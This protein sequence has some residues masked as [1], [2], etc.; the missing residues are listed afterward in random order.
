M[1]FYNYRDLQLSSNGDLTLD[2]TGDLAMSFNI[3]CVKE[4]I[5][6]RLRTENPDWYHHPSIG[7]DIDTFVGEPNTEETAI[8]VV[9]SIMSCLTYD[10]FLLPSMIVVTPIP[11]SPTQVIYH[12]LVRNEGDEISLTIKF[13]HD[14]GVEEVL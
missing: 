4:S 8:K 5:M 6:A 7:A 9:A 12:L 11:I 14:T 13:N 2:Q 3:Q 10:D 1:P